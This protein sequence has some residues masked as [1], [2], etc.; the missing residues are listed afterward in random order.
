MVTIILINAPQNAN[1]K[2]IRGVLHRSGS[3][4]T[5][6][7]TTLCSRSLWKN[8]VATWV[9]PVRLFGD[10]CAIFR[11]ITNTKNCD[12][13]W[14][15]FNLLYCWTKLWPLII[16]QSKCKVMRITN[17]RLHYTYTAPKSGYPSCSQAEGQ[18]SWKVYF[19]ITD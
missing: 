8:T 18:W 10:Y 11:L 13:L 4:N 7:C 6:Y 15:D 9:S 19:G 12:H 2:P 1:Q 3:E 17:V 5:S 14:A 16:N